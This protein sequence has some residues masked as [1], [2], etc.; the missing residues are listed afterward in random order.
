MSGMDN[1]MDTKEIAE[2]LGFSGSRAAANL[3]ASGVLQTARK[4]G[5]AWVAA[6]T[7]VEQYKQLQVLRGLGRPPSRNESNYNGL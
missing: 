5:N 4:K 2:F 3:C 7:E 1:I 6:R